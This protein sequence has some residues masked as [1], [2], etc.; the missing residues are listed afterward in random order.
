MEPRLQPIPLQVL[1]LHQMLEEEEMME[2]WLLAYGGT[3]CWMR[4]ERG[5]P[6][7]TVPV[8]RLGKCLG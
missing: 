1:Y 3:G 5:F 4:L 2:K 8:V 6:M 7:A